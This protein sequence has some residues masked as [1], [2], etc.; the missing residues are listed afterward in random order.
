MGENDCCYCEPFGG[1]ASPIWGASP[2][3]LRESMP[4]APRL[5]ILHGFRDFSFDIT[6]PRFRHWMCG[7]KFR[8]TRAPPGTHSLPQGDSAVRI[9]A[10]LGHQDKPDV[11]CLRLMYAAI[12]KK[13]SHLCSHAVGLHEDIRSN[14][15]VG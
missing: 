12:R 14:S 6:N 9:V 15:R 8:G 4:S 7:K 2:F 5:V 13:K 10:C 11:V 1:T 3:N